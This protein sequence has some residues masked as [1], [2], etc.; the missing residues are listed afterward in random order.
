MAKVEVTKASAPADEALDT[1]IRPLPSMGSLWGANPFEMMR[2]MARSLDRPLWPVAGREGTWAP[3]IECS[4]ENGALLVK[5]ELP[6]LSREDV[7]VLILDESLILE[8]ERKLE[9]KE[10]KEGYFR[11]ERSYGKFWRQ[12]PL[13][14]G[15][16]TEQIKAS[17]HDGVL[18][19][20]IPVSDAKKA[21]RQIPIEQTGGEPAQQNR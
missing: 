6:G 5:A 11:S 16:D 4:R 21:T 13:P 2:E 17:M 9:S 12:I 18:E 1:W 19:V 8:G 15:A 3:A 20:K 10:E 7:K 14:E